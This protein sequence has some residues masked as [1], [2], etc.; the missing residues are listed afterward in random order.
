MQT[1]PC[2]IA[3]RSISKGSLKLFARLAL[4]AVGCAI[5]SPAQDTFNYDGYSGVFTKDT[6][7]L[8]GTAQLTYVTPGD[9]GRLRLTDGQ[10]FQAGS[11][12]YTKP[13][14][15]HA[16]TTGFRFQ[17]SKANADGFAFVLQTRG[18]EALGGAGGDLGVLGGYYG[19]QQALAITFRFY[20]PFPDN[21]NIDLYHVGDFKSEKINSLPETGLSLQGIELGSG[22]P[23]YVVLEYDGAVL[24]MTVIDQ[25]TGARASQSFGTTSLDG[26]PTTGPLDIP[27]LL[28]ADSAYVGFSAG[29]GALTA[30]Q[31]ILGWS[32]ASGPPQTVPAPTITPPANSVVTTSTGVTIAKSAPDTTVY[33]SVVSDQY[34][35]AYH[36]YDGPFTV[37]FPSATV[38]AYAS[39]PGG[40]SAVTT[41]RYTVATPVDYSSGFFLGPPGYIAP[42]GTTALYG[43][44]LRLT[45]GGL[46]QAGAAWLNGTSLPTASSFTSD[47]TFQL[48]NASGD[49]IAFV[50]QDAL[51]GSGYAVGDP[52]G[53][54]GY[55]NIPGRSVGIKFD[56]FSNQGESANSTGLYVNGQH[57]FLP[58]TDLTPSGI[59]LH[60]GHPFKVHVV[61]S[62]K[63]HTL[64]VTTTDVNTAATATQTYSTVSLPVFGA[65]AIFGFTGGTGALTAT[66]DILNWTVSYAP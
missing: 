44:R 30:T 59:D 20:G 18:R 54:L 37:P 7:S 50:L 56:L 15:I 5:S 16:F 52:G 57:P 47:F 43:N 33:F 53:D 21:N 25:Q 35:I 29:T 38:H 60:S 45:N 17:L 39:G 26:G 63:A 9:I 31:D 12:F 3:T 51:T 62:A 34:S 14:N 58:S 41:A 4:I 36:P 1:A 22:H 10:T 19:G 32:Y 24:L 11:V 46:N 8:N 42:R 61:Y 64:T 48:T 28:G 13:V 40:D 65:N 55:A 27:T 49:G 6:L 23:F 66:Q 2:R